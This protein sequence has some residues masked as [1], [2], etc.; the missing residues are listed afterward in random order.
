[1][2]HSPS[3]KMA[4]EPQHHAGDVVPGGETRSP[5]PEFRF[6]AVQI[7]LSDGDMIWMIK[8]EDQL[9][10]SLAT[11]MGHWSTESDQVVV[12]EKGNPGYFGRGFD[13]TGRPIFNRLVDDQLLH[14]YDGVSIEQMKIINFLSNHPDKIF[15]EMPTRGY[16]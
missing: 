5:I 1:M 16:N 7:P 9:S 3:S 11:A 14:L 4:C 8:D 13:P 15:F 10:F 2:Y 12:L 6:Q